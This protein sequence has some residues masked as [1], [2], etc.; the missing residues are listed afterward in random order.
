MQHKKLEYIFTN[1]F[2]FQLDPKKKN[3]NIVEVAR[4]LQKQRILVVDANDRDLDKK[5]AKTLYN[6]PNVWRTFI[7]GFLK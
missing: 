3:C 1:L 4:K 2:K 7:R 5:D 6:F